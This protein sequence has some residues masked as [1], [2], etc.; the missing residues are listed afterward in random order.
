[1][2]DHTLMRRIRTT[3]ITLVLAMS[4]NTPD[5][6]AAST[7]PVEKK[8]QE[9]G[10]KQIEYSASKLLNDRRAR[11]LKMSGDV[12]FDQNDFELA[13]EF[14]LRALA[15]APGAFSVK[16]KKII[17]DRLVAANRRR[18]AIE[19]LRQLA[20][21]QGDDA[22]IRI[23]LA[24]LFSDNEDYAAAIA[25]VDQVLE[26]DRG[27][28]YALLVK[29]NSLRSQQKFGQSII[30][31]RRILDLD[32]DFD[33]RLGLT[34]SLLAEGEKKKARESF[35]RMKAEGEEQQSQIND[36]AYFLD[37][38][39]RPTVDLYSG[40]FT[41]SDKNRTSER[42][43]T[44]RGASTDWDLAAMFG[45]KNALSEGVTYA[46]DAVTASASTNF[47]EVLRLTLKLGQVKLGAEQRRSVATRDFEIDFKGGFQPVSIVNV[48]VSHDVVT[49]TGVQI[50]NAIEQDQS[51]VKL[52]RALDAKT[53]LYLNYRYRQYSDINSANDF[54][55]TAQR[56]VFSGGPVVRVGYVYRQMDYNHPTFSGY[57]A[58]QNYK[59]H[60]GF[61]T[62]YYEYGSYYFDSEA[63]YGQQKYQQ[64]FYDDKT[65]SKISQPF[66]Y[67]SATLGTTVAKK[68]R[69]EL[70]AEYNKSYATSNGYGYD[71]LL[72]NAQ[73]SYMF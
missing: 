13:A 2:I 73:A 12:K 28:R 72:V 25:Q 48:D 8:P 32:E 64:D 47:S 35:G 26:Q 54:Q 33:A 5:V 62:L 41:D 7:A 38:V 69:L 51:S 9:P 17:A 6:L 23:S 14:Y 22:D 46:A 45:K 18:E 39:T 60:Q 71:D 44:V 42:R 40:T 65:V 67:A 10:Q 15:L 4:S 3:A 52:T 63:D 16:E 30:L 29:A 19:V 36:L 61:V 70:H 55:G 27:N 49:T 53:M 57:F 1:M 24:K 50:G 31:Y 20:L 37:S 58:P 56:T 34:Y 21:E 43:V 59:S 68:F 66:V 11:D